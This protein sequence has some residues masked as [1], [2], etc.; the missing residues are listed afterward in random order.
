V[1]ILALIINIIGFDKTTLKQPKNS[2]RIDL[3]VSCKKNEKFFCF[4]ALKND[5]LKLKN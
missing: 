4:K 1:C 3:K 5:D 2:L